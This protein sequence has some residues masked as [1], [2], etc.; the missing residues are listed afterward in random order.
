VLTVACSAIRTSFATAPAAFA[1]S[2][3]RFNLLH[4][5]TLYCR[6]PLPP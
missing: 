6:L 1:S 2:E 5:S 4:P 3:T